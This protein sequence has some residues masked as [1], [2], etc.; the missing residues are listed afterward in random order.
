[1]DET[2][3]IL[4]NVEAEDGGSAASVI[5]LAVLAVYILSYLVGAIWLFVEGW[6]NQFS[7]LHTFWNFPQDKEFPV[8]FQSALFSLTGSIMGSGVLGIASFYRYV[9]IEEAF[10]THHLWGYYF[11]PVLASV[12]GLVVFALLQSGLLVFSGSDTSPSEVSHLGYLSIGFISGYGWYQFTAKIDEL[13]GKL[14]SARRRPK[15]SAPI[16]THDEDELL[17]STSLPDD[18]AKSKEEGG[19]DKVGQS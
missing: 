4:N 5:A 11:A 14:L 1:M 16:E 7:A 6:L 18:A 19:S 9:S 15:K 12:I 17:S 3:E 13:V 8:M 10:K 2:N